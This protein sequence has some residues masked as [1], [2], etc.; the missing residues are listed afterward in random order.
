MVSCETYV[1][2]RLLIAFLQPAG[3]GL[4]RPVFMQPVDDE[5]AQFLDAIENA[6]AAA[7]GQISVLCRVGIVMA[8]LVGVTAQFAND[9]ARAR[10]SWRAMAAMDA[11]CARMRTMVALSPGMRWVYCVIVQRLL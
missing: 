2:K 8:A 7:P 4:W 5:P 9:G 6:A 1:W 11:P 3:D 10:P